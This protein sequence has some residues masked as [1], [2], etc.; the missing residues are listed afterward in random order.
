[1]EDRIASLEELLE[2]MARRYR[3]MQLALGTVAGTG[4]AAALLGFSGQDVQDSIKTRSLTIV[5]REGNP[6]VVMGAPIDDF[7][8]MG[9]RR[10]QAMSGIAILDAKR[11]EQVGIGVNADGSVGLGLDCRPGV[12][13]PANRERINLVVGPDGSATI[14]M[15]D[16]QTRLKSI[17]HTK[18]TGSSAISFLKW[19]GTKE[20]PVPAEVQTYGLEAR[21]TSPAELFE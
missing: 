9:V 1:M 5:D 16:N 12:G 14:R 3:R 18:A 6:R 4:V 8:V 7:A 15:L 20:K 19:A 17:W 13:N 11:N 2:E 21:R 10:V